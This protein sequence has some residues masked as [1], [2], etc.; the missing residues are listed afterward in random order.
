MGKMSGTIT[1]STRKDPITVLQLPSVPSRF[2]ITKLNRS[3]QLKIQL[4]D[5]GTE[6]LSAFLEGAIASAT[7]SNSG[8]GW[9]LR[10]T[11][12]N[13]SSSN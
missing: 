2:T 10:E 9:S 8:S 4:F 11:A 6:Q 1:S 13:L 12:L 7:L 5:D 3:G